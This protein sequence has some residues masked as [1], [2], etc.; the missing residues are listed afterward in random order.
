[1]NDTQL[2]SIY[3]DQITKSFDNYI[4]EGRGIG[5]E[6]KFSVKDGNEILFYG[7][8]KI[9]QPMGMT[10]REDHLPGVVR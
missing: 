4:F 1:M 10:G 7:L 5:E 3:N 8:V 2:K 9:E 6:S